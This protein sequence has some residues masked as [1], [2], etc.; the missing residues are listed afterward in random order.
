M[1]KLN[2]L[3]FKLK[4][5]R[6]KRPNNPQIRSYKEAVE[7]GLNSQFVLPK[8][9]SWI[10]KKPNMKRPSRVFKTQEEAI[11]FAKVI[12]QNQGTAV[13]VHNQGGTIQDRF[14]YGE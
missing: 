7:K 12:A 13:F 6:L 1:I 9:G 5:I 8:N 2:K 10:V 3:H 14:Y 11:S 4:S